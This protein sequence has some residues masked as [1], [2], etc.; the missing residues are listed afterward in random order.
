MTTKITKLLQTPV[1]SETPR[2]VLDYQNLVKRAQIIREY[3]SQRIDEIITDSKQSISRK[4]HRLDLI[5]IR[6]QVHEI[7]EDYGS[8]TWILESTGLENHQNPQRVLK[9]AIYK[10]LAEQDKI[11]FFDPQNLFKNRQ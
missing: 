11:R 6:D 3:T 10:Y 9:A 2:L 7:S 4:I 8:T 1:I 5:F